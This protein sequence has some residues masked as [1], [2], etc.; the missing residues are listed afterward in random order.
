MKQT[1]TRKEK[2]CNSKERK[3]NKM[4]KKTLLVVG[5]ASSRRGWTTGPCVFTQPSPS[6]DCRRSVANFAPAS[7]SAQPPPSL[8]RWPS[9]SAARPCRGSGSQGRRSRAPYSSTTRRAESSSCPPPAPSP[10]PGAFLNPKPSLSVSHLSSHPLLDV[11]KPE[12]G[13]SRC[14]FGCVRR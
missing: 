2:R 4:R 6:H 12:T 7:A 1:S 14:C 8:I 13:C 3:G 9:E 11:S 5:Y 10:P